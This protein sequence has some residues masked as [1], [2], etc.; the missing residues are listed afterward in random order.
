MKKT[1]LT[2]LLALTG[3]VFAGP[4]GY[5]PP[6][7]APAP[8]MQEQLF[9]PGWHL[10]AHGL[11]LTPDSDRKDDTFGGG[12]NVDYFFTSVVGT[13]LSASWADPGTDEIWHNYTLDLV[14]RAPIESAYIAPYVLGGGGVILEDS[15][16]FLGRVGVG[17]EFRPMANLGIFTDWIY[18]FPGGGG[19]ENDSEDYQ[20]IR[21]GIKFGF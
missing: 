19:G 9:G 21:A 20:M 8:V 5:A 17:L 11:F 6:P 1:L 15:S 10:G 2:T 14:L 12:V 4:P 16:D 3:S 18:S 7:M 13:Q